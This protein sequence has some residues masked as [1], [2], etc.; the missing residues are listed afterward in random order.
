MW[1]DIKACYRILHMLYPLFV[2]HMSLPLTSSA[3]AQDQHIFS[4]FQAKWLAQCAAHSSVHWEDSLSILSFQATPECDCYP[5]LVCSCIPS[6]PICKPELGFSPSCSWSCK[7]LH[8]VGTTMEESP[9]TSEIG[10]GL[11]VWTTCSPSLLTPSS[12]AQTQ[13][14][15]YHFYFTMECSNLIYD[16][17]DLTRLSP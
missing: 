6:Q 13:S 15:L 16:F 3:T 2:L 11:R 9:R 5:P 7:I 12:P 17:V 4:S 1:V 14:K 10:G 8:A